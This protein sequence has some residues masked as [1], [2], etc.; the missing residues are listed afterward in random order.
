MLKPMAPAIQLTAEVR[1]G[2]KYSVVRRYKES[3]S[4]SVS[5]TKFT[6]WRHTSTVTRTVFF[7]Y[8]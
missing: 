1:W 5:G 6:A 7:V 8:F 2:N 3:V 4:Y